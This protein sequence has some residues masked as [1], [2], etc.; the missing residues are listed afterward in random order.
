MKKFITGFTVFALVAIGTILAFAQKKS[1]GGGKWGGRG[2]G[3]HHRGGFERLAEKLDLTDAQ[4]EQVKQITEASRAK[5]KPLMESVRANR[6]K[7]ETLTA[8]GQFDE[9]QIQTVAQEQGAISAQLIVEKERAKW[10]IFQILTDE[11]KAQAAQLKEQMKER[12]KDKAK[13]FVGEDF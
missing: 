2:F 8:N 10:Q 4:K 3:G 11:Q 6:Q 7:M 5:I 9:A 1:D 12:F 13:K